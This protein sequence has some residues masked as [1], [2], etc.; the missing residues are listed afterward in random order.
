MYSSVVGYLRAVNKHYTDNGKVAPFS[1]KDESNV[2]KVLKKVKD[3]EKAQSCC[4]PLPDEALAK[5]LELMIDDKNPLGFKAAVWNYTALGRFGGFRC[6]EFAMDS[7]TTIRY[8]LLP[9]G[10]KLVRCF[11]IRNFKFLD[12]VGDNVINPLRHRHKVSTSG[13]EFDVQKKTK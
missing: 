13:V 4:D 9:N 1:L 6:G 3:F 8:Y 11:T 10:E 2:A 5:M 7:R 12:D